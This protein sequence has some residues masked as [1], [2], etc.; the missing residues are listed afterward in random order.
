MV[1]RYGDWTQKLQQLFAADHFLPNRKLLTQTYLYIRQQYRNEYSWEAPELLYP[2]SS[3]GEDDRP[4][5]WLRR[6]NHLRD[7]D[8]SIPT[9][10]PVRPSPS[11]S[12]LCGKAQRQVSVFVS[13]HFGIWSGPHSALCL[14]SCWIGSGWILGPPPTPCPRPR[15]VVRTPNTMPCNL[16]ASLR[17]AGPVLLARI[18]HNNPHHSSTFSI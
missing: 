17:I 9:P 1:P 12:V 7:S 18:L 14:V 13:C 2:A 6:L 11:C 10:R 8:A 5:T 3:T 15:L 4:M 16:T